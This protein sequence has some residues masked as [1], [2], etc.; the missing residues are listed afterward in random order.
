MLSALGLSSGQAAAVPVPCQVSTAAPC[1]LAAP[2]SVHRQVP[3]SPHP[4]SA[5]SGISVRPQCERTMAGRSTAGSQQEPSSC[6]CS[7]RAV[8]EEQ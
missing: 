8:V 5:C 4:V 6:V 2:H 1:Y 3:G 7:C